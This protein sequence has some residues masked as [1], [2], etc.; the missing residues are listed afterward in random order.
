MMFDHFPYNVARA[1][2]VAAKSI[3][4]FDSSLDEI[5]SNEVVQEGEKKRS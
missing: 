2:E 5:K 1:L 4:V 3:G